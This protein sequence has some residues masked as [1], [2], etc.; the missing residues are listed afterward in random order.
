MS[1]RSLVRG[2][3][4]SLSIL[5]LLACAFF[6]STVLSGCSGTSA[7]RTSNEEG[8]NEGGSEDVIT[9]EDAIAVGGA[10]LLKGEDVYAQGVYPQYMDGL[11]FD[12]RSEG[13][14]G[15]VYTYGASCTERDV[16]ELPAGTYCLYNAD[17]SSFDSEPVT[18]LTVDRNAGDTLIT[19][20]DNAMECDMEP[21]LHEG[22]WMGHGF[23]IYYDVDSNN[24]RP[25]YPVG[26]LTLNGEPIDIAELNGVDVSNVNRSSGSGSDAA[27]ATLQDSDLC[28]KTINIHK[29][30][31]S[32]GG[33]NGYS[34]MED[35]LAAD[36][37]GQSI[38]I[39]YYQGSEWGESDIALDEYYYFTGTEQDVDP[40]RT[41]NGY[42][43][44]DL[45]S[46]EPGHYML[47]LG[48]GKVRTHYAINIV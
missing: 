33:P 8:E 7:Q 35:I 37:W 25:D 44:V 13:D 1:E 39:G 10:Y 4:R 22:F 3:A 24:S 2:I 14:G 12:S 6:S 40:V 46:F 47:T 32:V 48:N 36:D 16:E 34:M 45:S 43:I 17:T 20:G 41:K 18:Y 9:L 21:V 19:T 15:G 28:Y 11:R 38:S 31:T 5:L 29:N 27:L 26:N 42:C 23:S 30:N